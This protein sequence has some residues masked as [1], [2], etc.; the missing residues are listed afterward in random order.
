MNLDL[1]IILLE[2]IKDN[3]TILYDWNL[4]SEI[5]VEIKEAVP[6]R[7]SCILDECS[8]VGFTTSLTN[9]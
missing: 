8:R 9:V 2:F 7:T 1:P 3:R 6:F 4:E 5:D